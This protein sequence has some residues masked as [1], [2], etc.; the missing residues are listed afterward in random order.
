MKSSV[1]VIPTYNEAG[2]IEKLITG[3]FDQ[4]KK[5]SNWDISIL[6]VDSHSKDNTSGIVKKLQKN[7]PRLYLL[8]TE[9][10]GLGKAYIDGYSYVIKKINP[11]AIVQMDADLSHN[12]SYL[13][14]FFNKI[15][16][17]ADLVLG[18]RYIRGGSIPQDWGIH[19]KFFS[20]FGNLIFRLG[21]MNFKIADW[22]SGYRAIKTWLVRD[23]FSH[24]KN[25]SGYVFQVA[26]LDFAIKKG[27]DI[28][29]VPINF[30]DR[31]SGQSKIIFTQYIL[32]NFYYIFKY[33]SFVKYV[34]VGL[35]GAFIDFGISF[36]L[37]EKLRIAK[38]L[39]WLATTISA[40]TSIV[41]N[42]L[43]NNY[44]SFSH[45]KID[46]GSIGFFSSFLKFNLVSL[47]ALVIQAVGIQ[48]LTNLFGA[49]LWYLYKIAIL[50]FIIIPYSYF[51]YNKIV[52][53]K[54]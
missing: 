22:T 13:P 29:E 20:Y 28:K 21:F 5:I 34:I 49:K 27:A 25:Y 32:N 15:E 3:I 35:I 40:E 19:R 9:K 30:V 53:K 52:W 54:K 14:E 36:T 31:K 44:W 46:G 50:A 43:F 47:G 7:Y 24:I 26:M 10:Q 6:I 16:K 41:S 39:Y 1:V 18:S 11:F 8:E 4:T 38:K 45:K 42:F 37:I 17:G 2:N 12:P 51:F 33:S 48:L 23:A